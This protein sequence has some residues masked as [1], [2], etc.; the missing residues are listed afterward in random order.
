M[1]VGNPTLAGFS[2]NVGQLWGFIKF[3]VDNFQNDTM[4]PSMVK[5]LFV[6]KNA[7][8]MRDIITHHYAD[9]HAE[10]VY[11]T[12]ERKIPHLLVT[13]QKMINDL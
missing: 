8:G 5:L 4:K 1:T 12:C 10:T 7:K 13:I 6:L 2:I 3:V 9:I 11:Y